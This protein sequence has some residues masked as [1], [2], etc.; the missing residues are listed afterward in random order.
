MLGISV[1]QRRALLAS[2]QDRA[3]RLEFERDQEG[4]LGAAAERAR[5]AREMHDIVSHNL[6][7]MIGLADG[8]TYALQSSPDTASSAMGRVSATGRQALGEMRRLLGVLRDDPSAEPLAPQPGVDRLDDLLAKV[9]A[10]GIHTLGELRIAP[11]AVLRPL[12][13]HIPVSPGRT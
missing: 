12:T 11:D 1:R 7:V 10:A 8:G 2:L 6:T 4:R 5:I 13:C 9:E 3:A